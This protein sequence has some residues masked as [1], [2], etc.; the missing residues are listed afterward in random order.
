MNPQLDVLRSFE[1]AGAAV[2]TG[3]ALAPFVVKESKSYWLLVLN[4]PVKLCAFSATFSFFFAKICV[5]SAKMK[6]NRHGHHTN[7]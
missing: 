4:T 5:K 1:V 7:Y 6:D 3:F 2:D